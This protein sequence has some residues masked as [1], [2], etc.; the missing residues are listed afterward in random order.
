VLLL[1]ALPHSETPWGALRTAAGQL[2]DGIGCCANAADIQ[3]ASW[4]C[5]SA[6]S[7]KGNTLQ[8]AA[9]HFV[10]VQVEAALHLL[11]WAA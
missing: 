1:P 6:H 2:S 4:L 3:T 7:T 11:L 10:M 8:S 5:C 9:Q